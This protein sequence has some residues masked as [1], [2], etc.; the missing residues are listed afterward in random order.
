VD[1]W[2]GAWRMTDAAE[3]E[4][5]LAMIAAPGVRFRDRYSLLEGL[6]DLNAHISASQRFM[7]GFSLERRGEIR[8]C[9]GTVLAEWVARGPDGQDRMTG[10]SVFALGM[11]GK[12][13]AVTGLGN[14]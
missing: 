9:Q 13:E 4:R 12:I 14:G 2:Y 8:H 1:A 10:T 7:P 3:R 5:A 6:E 11:E